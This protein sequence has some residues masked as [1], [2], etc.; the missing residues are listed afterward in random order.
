MMMGHFYL[1]IITKKYFQTHTYILIVVSATFSS[2][3]A[4]PPSD[5]SPVI[6]HLSDLLA[7]LKV[8]C[9]TPKLFYFYD[10]CLFVL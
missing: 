1:N 10:F 6:Q 8:V 3:C 7:C 2:F 5:A 9:R 4:P